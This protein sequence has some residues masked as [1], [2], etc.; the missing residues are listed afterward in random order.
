MALGNEPPYKVM[1]VDDSAVIR[2]IIK[3]TL[4]DDPSIEVVTTAH[5][6]EAAIKSLSKYDIE[7]VVLDIEMPVMDGLT[8]LPKLLEEDK[9]LEIIM[10]S[11]LTVKGAE[12]SIKALQMGAADY[13]AKPTSTRDITC[14]KEYSNELITKIKALGAARRRKHGPKKKAFTA[15]MKAPVARTTSLFQKKDGGFTLRTH[16]VLRPDVIAIGSST[17]GPQA[18]G[19]FF[20]NLR[21]A[22]ITQPIF[23]TQH[24]PETFTKILAGHISN[25]YGKEAKEGEDGEVVKNGG[26]YVAPGGHHMIV[27]KRGAEKVIKI[28]DTP[29]ENF[30]RPS[31]EPMLRS[32][33][34]VYGKKILTVIFTGMG[35]DGAKASEKV[36][37]A[38]GSVV[39]QDEATSV[40]WGM[41]GAVSMKNICSAVL[42]LDDIAGYVKKIAN[43]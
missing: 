32:I 39:A 22:N 5:N 26:V 16:D 41:P 13:I 35:A 29:P 42:P 9:T 12:V 11:T 23:I 20:T 18:L 1:I 33:L 17:G 7:L 37:E 14:S 4:D 40:V 30:C 21:G 36:V 2:G 34:D 15:Q 31:V 38:G 25:F 24:M 19:K 28:I 8:A 6:G 27:E 43:K 3:K 10:F